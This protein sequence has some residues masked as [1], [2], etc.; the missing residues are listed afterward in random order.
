[1]NT[2]KRFSRLVAAGG[3]LALSNAAFGFGFNLQTERIY[4]N[5]V[6]VAEACLQRV[7]QQGA[8]KGLQAYLDTALA[9]CAAEAIPGPACEDDALIYQCM[10]E[11]NYRNYVSYST[12]TTTADLTIIVSWSFEGSSLTSSGQHSQ[13]FPGV[14]HVPEEQQLLIL[15]DSE[16]MADMCLALD[17]TLIE[18]PP[19]EEPPIEEPPVEEPPIEEPPIEEPPVEEPPIEEPPIEEPPVEEPPIEEPPTEEPPVEEPPIEEPPI[20][21]PPVEE[22]PIEEPPIEEPPVGAPPIGEPPVETPP[23]GGPQVG[24]PPVDPPQPPEPPEPPTQPPVDPNYPDPN[25]EDDVEDTG[26]E[27]EPLG[28][29]FRL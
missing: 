12:C 5:V 26:V 24:G 7:N 3:I 25:L 28:K 19:I 13:T 20:E 10:R 4:E 29:P 8:L 14:A 11:A 27:S 23:G 18:L 15:A 17:P 6:P 1:M 16:I 2:M 21:E 9:N 22:P